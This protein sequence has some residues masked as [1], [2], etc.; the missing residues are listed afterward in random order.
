MLRYAQFIDWL[1]MFVVL[2]ISIVIHV[3][4]LY[5][6]IC[7][8]KRISHPPRSPSV[9]TIVC[10][11]LYNLFSLVLTSVCVIILLS[12]FA[13]RWWWWN[14]LNSSSLSDSI[15]E[16]MRKNWKIHSNEQIQ[17]SSAA[18]RLTFLYSMYVS[19]VRG[20][21]SEAT[22]GA[23][24]RVGRQTNGRSNETKKDGISALASTYI[25]ISIFSYGWWSNECEWQVDGTPVDCRTR[26]TEQ[27][28]R[29]CCFVRL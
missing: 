10:L 6:P 25:Y 12:L 9:T 2:Y 5:C 28:A 8:S 21:W 7:V 14:I 11:W 27:R 13:F 3:V 24:A 22:E 19:M 16:S 1:I 29:A 18:R 26:L 17:W 15:R 20:Y 23:N 4:L